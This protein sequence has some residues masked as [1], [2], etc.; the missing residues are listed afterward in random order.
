MSVENDGIQEFPHSGQACLT[1]KFEGAQD[2]G[3]RTGPWV[4]IA[5]ILGFSGCQ[6]LHATMQTEK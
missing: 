3:L 5:V 2:S 6:S 1:V 4:G